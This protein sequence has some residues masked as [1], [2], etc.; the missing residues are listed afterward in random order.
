VRPLKR[1]LLCVDDDVT[2]TE[3]LTELLRRQN[4]EV[5]VSATVN[6]ALERARHESF[7]MYILD[8]WF[9]QGSGI[10][11]C[12]KIREFDPYTP[13]VFYSGTSLDSD[14]EEALFVGASAFV[15]KPSIEELL[16]TIHSIF[17]DMPISGTV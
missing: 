5:S 10:E 13:I 8:H 6:D 11:L 3:M 9:N 15:L 4:Y 12:R 1:R 2:T 7:S 16:S 17:S 14:R